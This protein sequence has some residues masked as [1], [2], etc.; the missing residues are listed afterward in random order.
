MKDFAR[1]KETFE[2]DFETNQVAD[3][4]EEKIEKF[5][6]QMSGADLMS[7]K[8]KDS[9]MV[10]NIEPME[11]PLNIHTQEPGKNEKREVDLQPLPYPDGPEGLNSQ[12][13]NFFGNENVE[14]GVNSK[15]SF[16]DHPVESFVNHKDQTLVE[17]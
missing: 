16:E 7:V 11:L 1:E 15:I 4:I 5:K 17:V 8:L 2:D 10:Q 14:E 13:I 6:D 12:P 3:Q 9:S